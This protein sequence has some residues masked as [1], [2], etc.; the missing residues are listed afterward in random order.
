M[1]QGQTSK[2]INCVCPRPFVSSK[3]FH[4]LHIIFLSVKNKILDFNYFFFSELAQGKSGR[5]NQYKPIPQTD[6]SSN[7]KNTSNGN[8]TKDKR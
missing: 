6:P 1:V 4:I 3:E 5:K 8:D 2:W 7:H